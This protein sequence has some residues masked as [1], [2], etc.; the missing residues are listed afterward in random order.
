MQDQYLL[1][2]RLFIAFMFVFSGINKAIYFQHGLE[3]VKAKH[4]PFPRL[5]LLAT[6]VV[7]IVCG[8]AIII[9]HFTVIA[10]AMLALFTLATALVFYDF[11]N[12]QGS[13]RTIMFTGF[14]EH[15]S[16]IG[17]F[18]ILMAAGPGRLIL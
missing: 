16:I 1:F 8:G 13:E 2:G 5:A 3:E 12:R 18:A 14:L 6:I 10:S 7:Q 11:W 9:G 15:I 4:L 17:G